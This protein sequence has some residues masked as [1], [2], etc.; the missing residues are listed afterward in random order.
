MFRSFVCSFVTLASFSSLW[1]AFTLTVHIY[2]HCIMK[3]Y[4][5]GKNMQLE[6]IRFCQT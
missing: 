6:L 3:V 2:T 1:P 4:M 5:E